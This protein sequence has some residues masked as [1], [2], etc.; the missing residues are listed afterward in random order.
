MGP[1]TPSASVRKL[2]FDLASTCNMGCTYCFADRGMY[3]APSE[4]TSRILT[5]EAA[6]RIVEK[7]VQNC[8]Q[9]N[10]VKFF[11]G[12][13]LLGADAIDVVCTMMRRAFDDGLLSRQ[14]TF[15]IITNGTIY[16][17]KIARMLTEHSIR[18][19]VSIDG[20]KDIH[21]AQRR[22]NNGRGTFNKICNNVEKLASYGCRLGV[23][24]AVFTPLHVEQGYSLLSLYKSLASDFSKDFE[25]IVVHP[26]DQ[27]TINELPENGFKSR[28]QDAIREQTKEL[29]EYLIFEDVKSGSAERTRHAID[30]LTSAAKDENLCGVGS[31]IITIKP[32][33]AVVSCYVFSSQKEFLYGNILSDKFW[34]RFRS[35]SLSSAMR[36]A[37]R[38]SHDACNACDI[39][40][41]CTHCLSGMDK[42]S[43]LN[44]QLPDVNCGFNI[45]QIEGIFDALNGLKKKD[46]FEILLRR[47][48]SE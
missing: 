38:F 31:D 6:A 21:D 2:V 19:T 44:S 43:G 25:M 17:E 9:I 13:P 27:P 11:G 26:M 36:S 40:K 35:G 3:G 23:L 10:H 32:D 33:G 29:Y 18:I 34:K 30:S 41:S 37:S 28:Y 42:D 5:A 16:S 15:N 48:A 14:P 8:D 45:G 12:E 4:P 22:F 46:E 20:P 7:V 39:Q 24:E 47:W 1:A